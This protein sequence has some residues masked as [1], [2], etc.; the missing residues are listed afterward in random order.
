MVR[1]CAEISKNEEPLPYKASESC[2]Y[3]FIFSNVLSK[4]FIP[5]KGA[6]YSAPVL[7][8]QLSH[9]TKSAKL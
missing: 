4:A 1:H 7:E 5:L 9:F 8:K 6:D 2:A 3:L